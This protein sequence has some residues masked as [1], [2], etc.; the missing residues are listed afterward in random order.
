[1]ILLNVLSNEVS[2]LSETHVT[3]PPPHFTT[4]IFLGLDTSARQPKRAQEINSLTF[5]FLT[6]SGRPD[7][8]ISS[9]INETGGPNLAAG[10][11][12]GYDFQAVN[13]HQLV[14]LRRGI[15]NEVP[16]YSVA[17][18]LLQNDIRMATFDATT[19]S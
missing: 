10:K 1:M 13:Y 15:F 5:T 17:M 18:A 14:T 3:H 6:K 19:K 9:R 4:F 2:C 16:Y 11:P 8:K 12:G 7:M